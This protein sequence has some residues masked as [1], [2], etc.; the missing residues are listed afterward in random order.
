MNNL[1][2]GYP[3]CQECAPDCLTCLD[4]DVC[5][6]CK[7]SSSTYLNLYKET[8]TSTCLPD[9]SAGTYKDHENNVC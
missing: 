4:I 7:E 1:E 9:C 6:K 5:T 2:I 8:S 3:Y